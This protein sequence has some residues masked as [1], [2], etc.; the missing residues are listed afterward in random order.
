MGTHLL[1]PS[2]SSGTRILHRLGPGGFQA[3]PLVLTASSF[4][5]VPAGGGGGV[6]RCS[7]QLELYQLLAPS[8]LSRGRLFGS[9]L[10][11]GSSWDSTYKPYFSAPGEGPGG[12]SG[13]GMASVALT[14]VWTRFSSPFSNLNT[15]VNPKVPTAAGWPRVIGSQWAFQSRPSRS[16][17]SKWRGQGI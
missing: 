8:L 10:A 5:A 4:A 12:G 16:S 6:R 9:A 14:L 1:P 11:L 13:D 7:Q 2:S 17:S 15:C 3:L